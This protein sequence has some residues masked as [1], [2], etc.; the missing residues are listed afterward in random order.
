M[1]TKALITLIWAI[2]LVLIAIII[3]SCICFYHRH[4]RNLSYQELLNAYNEL[5]NE[6]FRLREQLNSVDK[7]VSADLHK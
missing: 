2:A 4:K 6:N 7:S 3:C 5:H 1:A